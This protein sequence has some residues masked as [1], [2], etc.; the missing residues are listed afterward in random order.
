MFEQYRGLRKENYI[1][2]FGRLVTGLGSMI[3]PMMTLILSQ[4]M[5]VSAKGVSV[6][7]AA[8]MVGMAPAIYLGGKISDKRDKTLSSKNS[9][10]SATVSSSSLIAP[11]AIGQTV[12][13]STL[14]DIIS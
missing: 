5:G 9:S 11:S 12:D 3:W 1:L 6:L 7:L 13:I 4:K 8:A 2:A 14:G 10:L